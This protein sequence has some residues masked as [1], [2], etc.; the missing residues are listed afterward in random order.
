M[1]EA[2]QGTFKDE[3]EWCIRQLETGLL[4]LNPTPK[5]VEQTQRILKVLRSRKAP[6]VKKRHLMNQVFGDYR[7]KISIEQKQMEKSAVKAMTV[8]IQECDSKNSGS[9]AYRKCSSESIETRGNWFIPSDNSFRFD[10]FLWETDSEVM[11]IGLENLQGGGDCGQ[12]YTDGTTSNPADLERQKNLQNKILTCPTSGSQ[13][14]EFAFNFLIPEEESSVLPSNSK[15]LEM[16]NAVCQVAPLMSPDMISGNMDSSENSVSQGLEEHTRED[17]ELRQLEMK[18]KKT[19]NFEN[20]VENKK[21]AD[22]PKKKK[23]KSSQNKKASERL[24]DGEKMKV[25]PIEHPDKETSPQDEASQLRREVDWCV[26]Q[27]EFGLQ[28]QK[29]TQKQVDEALR[30]I[31]ILKSEKAPLVKKRQ[32]MRGMFGDYRKKMEDERQKQLRL[33]QAAT[34]SASVTEVKDRT[35]RSRS[36]IYRK[37]SWIA[38]Q[39]RSSAGSNAPQIRTA[40]PQNVTTSQIP[41]DHVLPSDTPR[42]DNFVFTSSQEPFCFN[43]F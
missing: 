13:G 32:V 16:G 29:S 26:E 1:E 15:D 35:Q 4:R 17:G 3:L 22:V 43:F 20:K 19:L 5:Q 25:G 31:K 37:C 11:N 34:K 8:K 27:L 9:V 24:E 33:M 7:Q 10:F 6:F 36:Q 21:L 14:S 18:E 23:K 41:Q 42:P 39:G 12:A 40:L 38:E 2:P 30:A 28:R